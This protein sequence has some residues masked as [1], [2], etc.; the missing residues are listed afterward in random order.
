[1]LQDLS[2]A[3]PRHVAHLSAV[4]RRLRACMVVPGGG[5]EPHAPK[6]TRFSVGKTALNRPVSA[7]IGPNLPS[8]HAFQ[9]PLAT[10]PH[11]FEPME[12]DTTR[13]VAG[14][15][16]IAGGAAEESAG[17][18]PVAYRRLNSQPAWRCR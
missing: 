10:P 8:H 14:K 2:S 7:A 17:S 16:R 12:R 1:M 9:A 6:G 15:S 18:A 11:P 3:G 13:Q 5:I 4:R